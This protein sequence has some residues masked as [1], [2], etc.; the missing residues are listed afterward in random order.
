MPALSD[1]EAPL[2][3]KV[4]WAE[5]EGELRPFVLDGNGGRDLA[6]WAP[7]PGGQEALLSCPVFEALLEGPRGGGKTDVLLMDFLRDTG[8]GLGAEWR[9]ILFRQSYPQLADLITKSKKWF[10]QIFPSAKFNEQRT[11]WTFAG[12]E[13]LRFTYV[14]REDDYW[15]YHGSS[16]PWIGFEELTT[17]ANPRCYTV[18]FS[19]CRSA[20]KAVPSRIR[21]TTNPYGPG[22]NW[23][24]ARFQLPVGSGRVVGKI[25][26]TEGEE[27]RVAIH[28][29]LHE[30]R[31][32]LHADPSYISRVRG[33]ARNPAELA[34]WIEGSWDIVAGG[35]IDDIWDPTIH[36][37]DDFEIP[38]SWRIDRS[39]DWGSSKPY[40]V[41][42][43]AR[44][45]GSDIIW[46]DKRRAPT[47]P[48]D[49]FR[50]GE[51]YGWN[52][53]PNEGLR[54]TAGDVAREIKRYEENRFPAR[55]VR[56]GP[57][58]S[59]IF[60]VQNGMSVAKD[61]ESLGIRW[62]RAHK[63]PGSRKNGWERLR[64]ML[65]HALPN[66]DSTPREEPGLFVA[67]SCRH[68]IRTVP[69]LPRDD[70]DLDDVNTEAE[71]HVGDETRYRIY[72][73][74]SGFVTT[75]LIGH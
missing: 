16:Y 57:A 65:G 2:A 56:P 35:M 51:L 44:S 21:A 11:T 31:V 63:G 49:L 36:V 15:N 68:F 46:P 59:S 17:W 14:Q 22:H 13:S 32:L 58:D 52:G 26:K 3:T 54:S 5:H 50:V 38:R 25:V 4:E 62:T 67:E 28:S 55:N 43:W 37:V 30:N 64:T 70:R 20:V 61:M 23:T 74:A 47:V 69:V 39:F 41:G 10:P 66:G 12:G 6:A 29:G 8:R 40:S 9:G 42:W 45:D 24:K 7:Q 75:K 19:L 33:A 60:D 1:A 53:S 27:D 34:A 71:D 73:S 72:R 18:M 48:G